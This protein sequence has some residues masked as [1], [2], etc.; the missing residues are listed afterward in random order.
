MV[1]WWPF[2][3]KILPLAVTPGLPLWTFFL[4]HKPPRDLGAPPLPPA[5]KVLTYL[6]MPV[7][8][9]TSRPDVQWGYVRDVKEAMLQ[10]VGVRGY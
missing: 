8:A 10:P 1:S 9:A 4:S 6:T 3:T 7:D 5:V 2:S